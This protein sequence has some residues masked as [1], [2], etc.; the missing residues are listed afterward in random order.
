MLAWIQVGDSDKLLQ[1][2]TGFVLAWHKCIIFVHVCLLV[3]IQVVERT[4]VT[5]HSAEDP[6]PF[7]VGYGYILDDAGGTEHCQKGAEC[8]I[9]CWAFANDIQS[10]TAYK[11]GASPTSYLLKYYVLYIWCILKTSSII[12]SIM[13]AD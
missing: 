6:G 3:W 1:F 2:K 9:T 13:T 11:V 8:L 10:V 5:V 7:P 4:T 12:I